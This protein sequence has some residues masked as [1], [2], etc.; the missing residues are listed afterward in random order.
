MHRHLMTSSAKQ[1]SAD[2]AAVVSGGAATWTWIANLN[3]ILQLLATVI[4]IVSGIYA[5]CYHRRKYRE[6][7]ESSE[8]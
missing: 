7:D 3:D 2:A 1:I 4:A 5:I 8:D 6:L